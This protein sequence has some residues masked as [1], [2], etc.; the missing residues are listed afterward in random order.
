MAS[1]LLLTGCTLLGST[2]YAALDEAVV[3]ERDP[4]SLRVHG[5]HGACD[6][7]QS[8]QVDETD[9]RVA[10]TVPLDVEPGGCDDIGLPVDV[11]VRL[12][13]PL[14]DREVVDARTGRVLPVRGRDRCRI[15]AEAQ[16]RPACARTG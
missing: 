10:V 9:R 14:G 5:I 11:A 6:Q 3:D 7:V 8:P 4:R 13:E 12:D 16:Q 1:A 15:D 2:G